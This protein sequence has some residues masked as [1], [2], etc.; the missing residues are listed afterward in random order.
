MVCNSTIFKLTDFL[1]LLFIQ[2]IYTGKKAIMFNR[3]NSD[4]KSQL[5]GILKEPLNPCEDLSNSVQLSLRSYVPCMLRFQQISNNTRPSLLWPTMYTMYCIY[6]SLG[7]KVL[8]INDESLLWL[9]QKLKCGFV[10][11]IHNLLV[12]KTWHRNIE[13]SELK[14]FFLLNRDYFG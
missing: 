1:F 13:A 14:S 6:L 12:A 3:S 8:E 4:W 11:C 5:S 9:R 2:N 10:K 7:Y